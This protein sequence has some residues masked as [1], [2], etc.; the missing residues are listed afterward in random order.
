MI[1]I[2]KFPLLSLILLSFRDFFAVPV[3]PWTLDSQNN[4]QPPVSI[5][6]QVAQRSTPRI[7][8]AIAETMQEP[9]TG[10]KGWRG[11]ASVSRPDDIIC[12]CPPW[13]L[14]GFISSERFA[15]IPW[16][17]ILLEWNWHWYFDGIFRSSGDEV[18]LAGNIEWI[19][20]SFRM[21]V[22]KKTFVCFFFFFL[23]RAHQS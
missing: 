13:E 23:H 9:R 21:H 12:H 3:F 4:T 22:T 2:S 1:I 6:V 20:S 11:S 10:W 5:V 19:W 14:H 15:P 8:I 7:I 17:T 18:L 16:E